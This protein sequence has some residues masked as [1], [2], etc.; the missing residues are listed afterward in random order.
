MDLNNLKS[1][2]C[3]KFKITETEKQYCLRQ[4]AG[5]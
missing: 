1:N 5:N 4:S 3:A 2:P